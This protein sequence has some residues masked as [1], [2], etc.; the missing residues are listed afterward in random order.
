MSG[1]HNWISIWSS[2]GWVQFSLFC[3]DLLKHLG[4]NSDLNVNLIL[5]WKTW[6]LTLCLVLT[7]S[8]TWLGLQTTNK[9]QIDTQTYITVLEYNRHSFIF[10]VESFKT[11]EIILFAYEMCLH[12]RLDG[13]FEL[14]YSSGKPWITIKST[15]NIL[16]TKNALVV[17]VSAQTIQPVRW[18]TWLV[19]SCILLLFVECKSANGIPPNRLDNKISRIMNWCMSS[20]FPFIRGSSVNLHVQLGLCNVIK[21]STIAG[22]CVQP[23]ST[24]L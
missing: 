15:D 2:D 3:W 12:S 20:I 9:A 19:N 7:V 24:V 22:S 8:T 11:F 23:V 18:V 4:V 5:P 16:P 14:F 21:Q 13:N 6:L 1:W 17:L 10:L